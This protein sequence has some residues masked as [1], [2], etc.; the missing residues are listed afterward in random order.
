MLYIT[1][2]KHI[3]FVIFRKPLKQSHWAVSMKAE[4]LNQNIVLN[5]R[6]RNFRNKI[7][8]VYNAHN[9]CIKDIKQQRQSKLNHGTANSTPSSCEVLIW[10]DLQFQ[11]PGFLFDQQ[12]EGEDFQF[13]FSSK[14]PQTT[15]DNSRED[16]QF[17]FNFWLCKIYQKIIHVLWLC[18]CV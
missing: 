17:A 6:I 18:C 14:S 2:I 11:G 12:E 4:D 13:T 7:A 3:R 15:K 5:V 16:F 9:S 1:R 8:P 10:F